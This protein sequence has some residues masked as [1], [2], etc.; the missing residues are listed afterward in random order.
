M[1]IY[2]QLRKCQGFGKKSTIQKQAARYQIILYRNV[3]KVRFLQSSLNQN[4]C[5][6]NRITAMIRVKKTPEKILIFLEGSNLKSGVSVT[7]DKG[8]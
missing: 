7:Q 1:M 5:L 6:I 4:Q 8:Q 2:R 3:P